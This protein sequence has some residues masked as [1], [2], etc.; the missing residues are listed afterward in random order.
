MPVITYSMYYTTNR[1]YENANTT[2]RSIIV[3]NERSRDYKL[4][5]ICLV[6]AL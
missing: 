2:L 3:F 6:V 1:L 5:I 4:Q